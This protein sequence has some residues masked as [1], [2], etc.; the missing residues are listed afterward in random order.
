VKRLAGV[1]GPPVDATDANVALFERGRSEREITKDVMPGRA[2]TRETMTP[3]EEASRF[4][5]GVSRHGNRLGAGD[6]PRNGNH[7]TTYE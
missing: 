2:C 1:A 7:A 6:L 3:T 5:F 4:L